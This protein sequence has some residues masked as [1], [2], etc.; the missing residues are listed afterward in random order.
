[1]GPELST[2]AA[3]Q[4]CAWICKQHQ[5]LIYRFGT[6]FQ[7]QNYLVRTRI[8]SGTM[9][10]SNIQMKLHYSHGFPEQKYNKQSTAGLC[11]FM[12]QILGRPSTDWCSATVQTPLS[13]WEQLKLLT[14]WTCKS[15]FLI[16]LFTTFSKNSSLFTCKTSSSDFILCILF[17]FF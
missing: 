14:S 12:V 17:L 5:D 10:I 7:D 9:W 2:A 3:D 6:N 8:W 4:N 15:Y 1:M 11:P 16:K 13:C